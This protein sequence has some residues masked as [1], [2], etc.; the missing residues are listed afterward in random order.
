[1]CE[2]RA[3][4]FGGIKFTLRTIIACRE[5]ICISVISFMYPNTDG[6]K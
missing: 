6:N 5:E 1:M 3:V 2:N 4:A